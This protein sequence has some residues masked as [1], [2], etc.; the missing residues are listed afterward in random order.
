MISKDNKDIQIAVQI[1]HDNNDFGQEQENKIKIF[2][3]YIIV[4]PTIDNHVSSIYTFDLAINTQEDIPQWALNGLFSKGKHTSLVFYDVAKD[5]DK[6]RFDVNKITKNILSQLLSQK[7]KYDIYFKFIEENNRSEEGTTYSINDDNYEKPYNASIRSIFIKEKNTSRLVS[8][9][10]I[11]DSKNSDHDI[12]T[13]WINNN[14]TQ[15]P[16]NN[17][18]QLL[19]QSNSILFLTCIDS[20]DSPSQIQKA[21]SFTSSINMNPSNSQ[22]VLKLLNENS[23]LRQSLSKCHHYSSITSSSSDSTLSTFYN[24]N[25]KPRHI[26]ISPS[27]P[28]N[29]NVILEEKE[30]QMTTVADLHRQ[31]EELENQITV[32][33]E[34]NNWVEAELVRLQKTGMELRDLCEK[35]SVLIDL[36]EFKFDE[37]QNEKDSTSK[38]NELSQDIQL[39]DKERNEIE[40]IY[41]KLENMVAKLSAAQMDDDKTDARTKNN[42]YYNMLP[43]RS[44]L[45]RSP[46]SSVISA[47]SSIHKMTSLR[48][49]SRYDECN[50]RM[51]IQSDISSRLMSRHNTNNPLSRQSRSTTPNYPPPPTDPPTQPLPP[52]PTIS[53]DPLKRMSTSSY[54]QHHDMD[55]SLRIHNAKLLTEIHAHQQTIKSL[56][57]Q[58]AEI[59]SERQKEKE[60]INFRIT[61]LSKQLETECVLKERAERA[62]AILE[63]R[64]D[65]IMIN[66]KSK[67]LC[68]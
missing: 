6:K 26:S 38:I 63:K 39:L 54:Q 13:S 59:Q 10:N 20:Q 11:I 45:R 36:L 52:I 66:K 47:T 44:S 68:F 67:F 53:P 42:I 30:E 19:E 46:D 49:T 33:R 23:L 8:Q 21:F 16:K 12:I 55:A 61:Y 62:R 14:E 22:L 31:I 60:E 58:L 35:Q 18:T 7:D 5:E 41:E 65:A 17:I 43:K 28:P 37:Y 64:L 24:S 48:N 27:L 4:L 2:E 50:K 15:H 56:E 25:D 29:S 51:S 3:N 34:R 9:L 57:S 32:T 1:L 40:A